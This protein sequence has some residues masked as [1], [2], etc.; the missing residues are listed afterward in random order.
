MKKSLIDKKIDKLLTVI[1][2]EKKLLKK[3][4]RLTEN[5]G[6]NAKKFNTILITM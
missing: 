1:V 3:T 5:I 4:S 6:V 2:S